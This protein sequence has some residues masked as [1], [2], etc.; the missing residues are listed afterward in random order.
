MDQYKHN[1][2]RRTSL[3]ITFFFVYCVLVDFWGNIVGTFYDIWEIHTALSVKQSRS[4]AIKGTERIHYK[5]INSR[6][7]TEPNDRDKIGGDLSDKPAALAA[8]KL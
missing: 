5:R 1:K 4:E 8:W 2:P 7:K 6:L 3:N